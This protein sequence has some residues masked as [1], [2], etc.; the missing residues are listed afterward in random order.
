[1][2]RLLD[3][4]RRLHGQSALIVFLLPI[5]LSLVPA[6]AG[7]FKVDVRTGI[8]RPAPVTW[9]EKRLAAKQCAKVARGRAD[10]AEVERRCL[11]RIRSDGD[12]PK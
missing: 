1:V 10:A 5:L 7:G 12:L 2:F 3:E 11:R 9:L 4:F 8:I 6:V